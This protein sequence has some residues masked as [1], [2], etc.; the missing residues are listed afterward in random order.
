ML[1]DA[2]PTTPSG[3][4][5]PG[6]TL[7]YS[8][9]GAS[10]VIG[11]GSTKP[12]L[13]YDDCNGTGYVWVAGRALTAQGYTL[14]ISTLGI[15]GAVISREF[16]EL[17]VRNG[18][19]DIIGNF[20]DQ[21]V[22][23]LKSAS[24]FVTVFAGGN[25]VNVILQAIDKGAGGSNPNAFVDQQVAA[26]NANFATLID[27]IRA[28]AKNARIIVLNLPNL[29]GLP[30]LAT[31]SLAQ[32]QLAQRAAVGITTA[33]INPMPGVTTIDLMCDARFYQASNFSADGFHPNDNL[34]AV[35]GSL[36]ATALTSTSYPAPKSGCSQMLLY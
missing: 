29:A 12:C 23:F 33:G 30:Y 35:M 16:Q 8:V 1:N 31:A 7:L 14:Q 15:P 27:D 17:G 36:I 24:T 5:E 6:S 10:D 26:F 13:P 18:R 34:Y 32:K 22:P 28:R 25:D 21:E 20:I 19:T 4:I 2:N 3:P 9:I 11:Y